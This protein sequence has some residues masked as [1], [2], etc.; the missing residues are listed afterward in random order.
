MPVRKIARIVDAAMKD[1][2]L[3][4]KTSSDPRFHRDVTRD[5]RKTLSSFKTVKH[6]LRDR[7]K[8]EKAKAKAKKKT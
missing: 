2:D 3:A 6:A 1:A 7:E 5:R 4:R 8:S